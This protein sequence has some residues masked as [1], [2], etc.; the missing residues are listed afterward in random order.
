[1]LTFIVAYL[2]DNWTFELRTLWIVIQGLKIFGMWFNPML[3]VLNYLGRYIQEARNMTSSEQF[4]H[5]GS[6]QHLCCVV[7]MT[8]SILVRVQGAPNMLE[9]KEL[10]VEKLM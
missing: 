4:L 2:L 8:P 3:G 6:T 5:E 1:M 10:C 9:L 7:G